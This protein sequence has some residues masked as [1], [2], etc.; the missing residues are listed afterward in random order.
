LPEVFSFFCEA[1]NL[2]RI[3]PS[4]LH[5]K[6]LGQTDRELR[7]GTLI[8]YELAWHGIPLDWTS[9][10][11]EWCPPTRFVDV[12]LKGPYRFWRH[13]HNFETCSGGSLIR[14]TVQYAVPGGVLG[15]LCAGWLVRRDVERIF[16]HRFRQISAIFKAQSAPSPR[17]GLSSES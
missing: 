10:I 4:W 2:N 11:E 15:D 5:F 17:R 1:R 6:V 16:D 13:T 7:A 14:D 12:Q 3:T 9:R 8:H